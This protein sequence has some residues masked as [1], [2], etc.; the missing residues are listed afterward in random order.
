M[1]LFANSVSRANVRMKRTKLPADRAV[2]TQTTTI[3]R[4]WHASAVALAAASLLSLSSPPAQAL[5]LGRVTVQSAL[6]EPLRVDIDIPEITP[7]E[8]ATLR[9][10]VASPDAFRAAGMEYSPALS[11]ATIT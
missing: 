9:T 3:K 11:G 2:V 8:V 5:A 10:T 6:G 1:V 4:Q 7:D